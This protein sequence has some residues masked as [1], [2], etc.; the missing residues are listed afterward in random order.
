MRITSHSIALDLDKLERVFRGCIIVTTVL[1]LMSIAAE[2][3]NPEFAETHR[4]LI[5]GLDFAFV[6]SISAELGIRLIRSENKRAFMRKHWIDFAFLFAF[7]GMT[8]LLKNL[9]VI[10]NTASVLSEKAGLTALSESGV[11]ESPIIMGKLGKLSF[12]TMHANNFAYLSRGSKL[13]KAHKF[14]F[15]DN[16]RTKKEELMRL[17]KKVLS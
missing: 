3:S 12:H 9:R 6:G 8:R 4:V 13:M 11:F 14:L 17:K 7:I 16:S 15:N 1:V 10:E 5:T 2:L